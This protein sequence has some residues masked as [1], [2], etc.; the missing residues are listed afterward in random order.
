MIIPTMIATIRD[1]HDVRQ[2]FTPQTANIPCRF[3]PLLPPITRNVTLPHPANRLQFGIRAGSPSAT[4]LKNGKNGN[5]HHAGQHCHPPP[6]SC[7]L[8]PPFPPGQRPGAR[9]HRASRELI[10]L[11]RERTR[12]RAAE[13]FTYL[14]YSCYQRLA[15]R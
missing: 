14:V 13:S 15:A 3:L 5:V 11:A 10:W 6:T 4:K 7:A 1:R 9:T 8:A 2:R 12:I